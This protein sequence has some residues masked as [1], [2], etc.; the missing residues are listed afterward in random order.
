[1]SCIKDK[2]ENYEL[3]GYIGKRDFEGLS[4]EGWEQ[5]SDYI[6]EECS[7]Y[8]WEEE[9]FQVVQEHIYKNFEGEEWFDEWRE[10]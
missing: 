8:R 4:D 9:I 1:M 10:Q 3:T 6:S 7:N 5:I 2:N